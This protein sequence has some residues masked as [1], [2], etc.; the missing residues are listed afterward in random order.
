MAWALRLK[1]CLLDVEHYKRPHPAVVAAV[2]LNAFQMMA[3]PGPPLDYERRLAHG[4][5]TAYEPESLPI[6][7]AEAIATNFIG[8]ERMSGNDGVRWGWDYAAGTLAGVTFKKT[9]GATPYCSATQLTRGAIRF[10]SGFLFV[11]PLS[12]VW[13]GFW[14]DLGGVRHRCCPKC[15]GWFTTR[16]S[17]K[18][19][20]S[21]ACQN[22]AKVERS[23][24]SQSDSEARPA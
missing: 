10:N 6:E 7:T 12:R 14:E 5:I 1:E 21:P 19:Y 4:D 3:L 22:A 13:F 8:L 15:G 11:S 16:R 17:T 9:W 18:R 23:R 24:K 2:Q 20:C